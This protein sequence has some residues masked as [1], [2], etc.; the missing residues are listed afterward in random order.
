MRRSYLAV[1]AAVML[2]IPMGMT[3]QDR[4]QG[5][6]DRSQ[7]KGKERDGR[8][9]YEAARKELGEAAVSYTHLRCRRRG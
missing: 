2:A 7:A 9:R 5:S 8:A 3:A 1:I 6:R 4:K